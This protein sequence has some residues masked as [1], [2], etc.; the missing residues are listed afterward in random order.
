[1]STTTYLVPVIA[2]VLGVTFRNESVSPVALVGVVV[3]LFGAY[4]ASRAVN[5][6][7]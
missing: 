7:E 6:Q 1:M 5:P 3:V 4:V 2:I